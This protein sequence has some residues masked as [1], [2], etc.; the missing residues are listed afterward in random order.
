MGLRRY[1]GCGLLRAETVGLGRL[2]LRS[3][4]LGGAGIGAEAWLGLRQS[5]GLDGYGSWSKWLPV[6]P[7][8]W[9]HRHIGRN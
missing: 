6:F 5:V 7:L 9:S 2:G 4:G 8:L 3:R 1:K